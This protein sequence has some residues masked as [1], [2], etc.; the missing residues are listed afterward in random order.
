[1]KLLPEPTSSLLLLLLL[2]ELSVSS[3]SQS[4]LRTSH[5]DGLRKLSNQMHRLRNLVSSRHTDVHYEHNL[6][7][8]PTLNFRP[9]DLAAVQENSTLFQLSSGLHSFKLHFDWLLYW[10]NQSGL[11]SFE[12]KKITDII[13]SIRILIQNQVPDLPSQNATLSLPAP[14]STWDVFKTSDIVHSRLQRFCGWYLRALHVL[15]Q[16]TRRRR[17]LSPQS[18]DAHNKGGSGNT[19]VNYSS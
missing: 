12:T 17:Q 6:T 7:S 3:M 8:L 16:S 14:T 19:V 5:K 1:M 2:V 9:H 18:K 10:Q 15:I 11:L 4:S 13:E